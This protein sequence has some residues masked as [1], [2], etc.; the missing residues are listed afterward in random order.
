MNERDEAQVNKPYQIL[1][2]DDDPD[3]LASVERI[4]RAT[5]WTL[6]KADSMAQAKDC[7][8]REKFAVVVA[9]QILKSQS[10]IEVLEYFKLQ[11]PST[12]RILLT[13]AL[14]DTALLASVNCAHVFR[15]ITKPWEN[16]NLLRDLAAAID[17]HRLKV[18]EKT[19][20]KEVSSQNRQ[21][22][23]LTLGL[24]QLV[25]ERTANAERQKIQAEK[26]LSHVRDL[27]RFIQQLANMNSVEEL[28][29]MLRSELRTFHE[30]R[31]PVLAYF[32]AH[33]QPR[34]LSFQ[35]KQV[36]ESSARSLW[37]TR[38]S[39][40]VNDQDDRIYLAN[41]F[42]RPHARTIAVPFMRHA[43]GREEKLRAPV[44]LFF[45]HALRDE[46]IDEVL[47][48]ISE[49]LQPLAI[50]ID[51]ILL[52]THLKFTS[53]QWESTFDGI[54]D[55]IAIVDS[56]HAVI[57]SNRH[58]SAA[59]GGRASIAACH[60]MFVGSD[61]VCR[62]CPMALALE[63]AN[64]QKGLVKKGERIFEV[65]SY[66]IRLSEMRPATNVINHYVDVTAAR[67]LNGRMIQ[68]EKMA[69]IGQLAGNIAHELNNPLT[70]IRSLAQVLLREVKSGV[71][72]DDLGEIERAAERS[73]KIIE[74]LLAF[75][76]GDTGENAQPIAMNEIVRRTLPMIKTA[77]RDHQ[78][79]I[80]LAED[81]AVVRVE[82]HLVQQVVF[83]LVNNAC[84]AMHKS[85]SIRIT[86]EVEKATDGRLW[87]LTRI[88]D[89]G[90]GIPP[91]IL[92]NIF[93]PFF[94]TKEKGKG[95]GLGLSMSRSI[96][97]RFGGAIDVQS[98]FGKGSVFT[99]RLPVLSAVDE[100]VM[101]SQV[102]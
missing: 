36:V 92:E 19:L 52:E 30:L 72:H 61:V 93:E 40:R 46:R 84:Q 85:G 57:R 31:P 81:E 18:A 4:F 53:L 17:H 59:Q 67:E 5:Q 34:L 66:P 76:K 11:S 6:V 23:R 69:A 96:I 16:K 10:G 39:I 13:G 60:K 89:T 21:L 22:E 88:Y 38:E 1:W 73:Q 43:A 82:P 33:Y 83:N 91:E 37:S 58:F 49:R 28:L 63:T 94:T 29:T 70:G 86:T 14:T 56:E 78:S 99:I 27:V 97:Q 26:Q 24:E 45:E 74:N 65:Y 54:K 55:P 90:T 100:S 3:I 68:S 102:G 8:A 42:G 41:E 64:P 50:T 15:F 20:V 101:S 44:T 80:D 25:A 51:R 35:G 98:E 95:T 7:L 77:M 62:G 87:S 79:E 9:D 75:S 71:V 12:S 47:T 32:G 48:V 2:V